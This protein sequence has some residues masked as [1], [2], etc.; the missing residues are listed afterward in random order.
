LQVFAVISIKKNQTFKGSRKLASSCLRRKKQTLGVTENLTIRR[1]PEENLR[2]GNILIRGI[3]TM[4]H[5]LTQLRQA[6]NTKKEDKT[7]HSLP[8]SY[9]GNRSIENLREPD[10]NLTSRRAAAAAS[11]RQAVDPRKRLQSTTEPKAPAAGPSNGPP[12]KKTG[13]SQGFRAAIAPTGGDLFRVWGLGNLWKAAAAPERGEA[14]RRTRR[15]ETNGKGSQRRRKQKA[16]SG[17]FFLE[18]GRP[19]LGSSTAVRS[20]EI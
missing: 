8:L 10:Q 1:H 14:Q 19:P 3:K 4:E 13:F 9:P 16:T 7:S 12:R 6:N 5:S 15:D 11:K 17:L 20:A 2:G 18:T